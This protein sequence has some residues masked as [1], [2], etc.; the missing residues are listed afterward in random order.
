[1][2][3]IV[4]ICFGLGGLFKAITLNRL[5]K[6]STEALKLQMEINDFLK[7]RIEALERSPK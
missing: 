3:W 5:L 6:D 4:L 7:E 2:I 1:M